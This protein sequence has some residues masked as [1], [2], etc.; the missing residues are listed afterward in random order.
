MH[1]LLC[2]A[3]GALIVLAALGVALITIVN[4]L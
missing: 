3:G 2:V 1:V 4:T